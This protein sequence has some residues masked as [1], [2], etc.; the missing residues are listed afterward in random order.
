MLKK[1][2]SAALLDPEERKNAVFTDQP[3][4]IPNGPLRNCT[5]ETIFREIHSASQRLR[6][7]SPPVENPVETC[8]QPVE[9]TKRPEK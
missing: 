4:V 6:T 9:E 3:G 8:G 1:L 7:S 5:V 2:H